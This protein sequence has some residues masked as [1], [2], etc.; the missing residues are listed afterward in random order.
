MA[1]PTISA[2][3]TDL[4]R[5]YHAH[6][7]AQGLTLGDWSFQVGT[8][9]FDVLDPT[10]ALPVDSSDQ[11]LAAPVGGSRKLGRVLSSGAAATA[12]KLSNGVVQIDGLSSITSAVSG[13]WMTISGAVDSG[14][15]GTWVIRRWVSADRV[16]IEAPL[17]TASSEA[18]PL[19]WELREACILRPNKRAIS[20]QCVIPG[21]DATDGLILGEIGIFCRVI[22]DSTSL[23]VLGDTI[24]FAIA[25]HPAQTKDT[26]TRIIQHIA[27]QS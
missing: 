1:D 5:K 21:T 13:R 8:T 14:L 26:E 12:T 7:L 10:Q 24:L 11:A 20:F 22:R 23:G 18:G 3:L 15:N 17:M 6:A 9:G 25:H 19:G 2:A 4:G 27:V 16:E